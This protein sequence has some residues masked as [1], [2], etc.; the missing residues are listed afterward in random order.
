M[1]KEFNI[2]AI[3]VSGQNKQDKKISTFLWLK[4]HYTYKNIQDDTFL[5]STEITNIIKEQSKPFKEEEL[6]AKAIKYNEFLHN[7]SIPEV[8]RCTLISTILVA[9]QYELF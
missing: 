7:Y 2:T 9:L 1:S 6:I 8:E 3:A 5:K 4:N